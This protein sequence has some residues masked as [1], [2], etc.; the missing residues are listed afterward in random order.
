MKKLIFTIL[1]LLCCVSF[2]AYSQSMVTNSS[3]PWGFNNGLPSRIID[4]NGTLFFTSYYY[5][6][7]TSKWGLFKSD[8]TTSGT[9]HLTD[10]SEQAYSLYNHDGVLYFVGNDV[11]NGREL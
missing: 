1:T 4:I 7:S 11:V 10:L 8:G 2:S 3:M 6:G 9:I 5:N